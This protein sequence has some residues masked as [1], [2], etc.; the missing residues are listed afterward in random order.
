MLV[1]VKQA[2]CRSSDLHR[3]AL[4]FKRSRSAG[5]HQIGVVSR[6]RFEL[7]MCDLGNRVPSAGREIGLPG[8]GRTDVEGVETRLPSSGRENLERMTGIEPAVTS[9]ATMSRTLL[10]SACW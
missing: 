7:S 4:R 10:T 5:S 6:E 1:P 8:R 3:E 2:W 9:L